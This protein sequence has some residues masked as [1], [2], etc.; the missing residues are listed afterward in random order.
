MKDLEFDLKVAKGHLGY[1]VSKLDIFEIKPSVKTGV[2][3]NLIDEQEFSIEA[4]ENTISI[5]KT[6]IIGAME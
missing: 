1:L 6:G 4:L 5:R 2:L 3:L